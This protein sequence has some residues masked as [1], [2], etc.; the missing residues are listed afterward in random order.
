MKKKVPENHGFWLKFDEKK[1][2][3]SFE[4]LGSL[5]KKELVS[6]RTIGSAS[7]IEI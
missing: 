7:E 1:G 4:K 3:E 2:R 5:T 6:F